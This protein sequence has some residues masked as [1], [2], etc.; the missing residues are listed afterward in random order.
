MS[1]GRGFR[2]SSSE[3]LRALSTSFSF[4]R[5]RLEREIGELNV[6]KRAKS[7]IS[8][9]DRPEQPGDDDFLVGWS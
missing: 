7:G 1:H 8:K 5:Q 2:G 9:M 3:D 6:E 4:R